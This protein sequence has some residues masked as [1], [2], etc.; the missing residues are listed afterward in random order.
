MPSG[1]PND[2]G[3]DLLPG[4]KP[5][6]VSSIGFLPSSSGSSKS[7][8]SSDG[9]GF[10]WDK[11]AGAG[12]GLIG[13]LFAPKKSPELGQNLKTIEGSATDL[14]KSGTDL[15]A[16]GSAAL[17][18]VLKYFQALASGDPSQALA[19]TSP[20]RG[21]VIDQYDSARR[22]AAQFTPRGGGQASS[23]QE[24]R[25]REAGQLADTTSQARS[26]GA[27]ALAS[28]GSDVTRSG[29]SA[30][31]A[32]IN[33]MVSTLQPLLEQQKQQGAD[34][35]KIFGGIGELVGSFFL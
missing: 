22:S 3:D 5:S 11:I 30:E 29:L 1:Q 24:S 18:P 32:S 20:Q 35:S 34:V 31:E 25:S 13:S 27:S 14:R 17:D 19:A 4:G 33:A 12:A 26:E 23:E 10:A 16:K 7:D 28:L 21:R 6:G 8:D 9:G 2:S 15:T